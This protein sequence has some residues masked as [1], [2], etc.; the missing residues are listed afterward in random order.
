M[1]TALEYGETLMRTLLAATVDPPLVLTA[2]PEFPDHPDLGTSSQ[3][4]IYKQ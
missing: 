4:D 1:E 2:L 3:T